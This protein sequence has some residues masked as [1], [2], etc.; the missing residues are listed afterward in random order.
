M[1]DKN[2]ETALHWS[3]HIGAIT[4]LDDTYHI[5]YSHHNAASPV[6]YEIR[7]KNRIGQ[8]IFRYYMDLSPETSVVGKVLREGQAVLNHCCI[9]K[10]IEGEQFQIR[11]DFFPLREKEKVIGVV[12]VIYIS[13]E[14]L[15]QSQQFTFDTDNIR[16]ALF[17]TSEILGMSQMIQNLRMQ[18]E[19]LARTTSS[20]L[21]YGETGT[22]KEMVAQSIHSC[23][24]RKDAPFIAQNCAAIP[25]TLLESI[26][27]GTTKGSYTGAENRA[28]IFESANGGTVFLDEINSLDFGLQAK[29]LRVLEEKKIAR[30]GSTEAI[31]VDVRIIAAINKP[32]M[33]CMKEN[34]L[35]PDLFYRLGCVM[36]DVPPLRQRR[37]DTLL[38]A[39]Y[40]VTLY[41]SRF[42][43]NI[44]GISDELKQFFLTYA[45]PGNVRELRNVIEGAFNFCEKEIIGVEDLPYYL[46]A[47]EQETLTHQICEER[48]ASLMQWTGCLRTY[49]EQCEQQKV[50]YA[51]SKYST[52]VAAADYLGISPQSL[53]QKLKKYGIEH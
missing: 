31:P 6:P 13:D 44:R 28:G 2:F 16:K 39:K 24:P 19:K 38:L 32:P 12:C 46:L 10:P 47:E 20:V 53:N 27:F 14:V 33:Q 30:I 4:I 48:E 50:L 5:V 21:I 23:G 11:Q 15:N 49:I 22:G 36:L 7:G 9:L 37:E 1:T 35:R 40:Y 3:Y 29:L 18:I 52:L 51:I 25:D 42:G 43:K 41:N 26:F 8:P 34:L 45:W 17:H